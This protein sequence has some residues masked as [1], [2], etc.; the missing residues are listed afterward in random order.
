[1]LCKLKSKQRINELLLVFTALAIAF[2]QQTAVAQNNFSRS[3]NVELGNYWNPDGVIYG[4]LGGFSEFQQS[5]LATVSYHES[6]LG[7]NVSIVHRFSGA[8]R[9][10]FNGTFKN[11]LN[12][13]KQTADGNTRPMYSTGNPDR[14]HID[15][16]L[17]DD[18]EEIAKVRQWANDYSASGIG[19]M[20]I[21][22]A[23]EADVPDRPWF[24]DPQL[25]IDWWRKFVEVV[26]TDA[27]GYNAPTDL[28]WL[29]SPT[30]YR[31]NRDNS[32]SNGKIV[33]VLQSHAAK[34]YP[35]A[36]YVDWIGSS[37][38]DSPCEYTGRPL[39]RWDHEG[40]L[41]HA[42]LWA[43]IIAPDKPYMLAEWGSELAESGNGGTRV[44]FFDTTREMLS[45]SKPGFNQIG[46]IVYFDRDHD[47]GEGDCNW[48]FHNQVSFP[49]PELRFD[50]G[51]NAQV[52]VGNDP[53]FWAYRRLINTPGLI[54]PLGDFKAPVAKAPVGTPSEPF[55]GVCSIKQVG[56][57]VEVNWQNV[58][59]RNVNLQ[60]DGSW[61]KTIEP[62][63]GKFLDTDV[64]LN[65]THFYTARVRIGSPAVVHD[66]DCGTI[67]YKRTV[68][69]KPNVAHACN[70]KPATH[71]GTEGDDVIV[72]T[73][74]N[75]V[76][77]GLG[78]NDRIDAL[79]GDDVICA[80]DGNDLVEGRDGNDIIF[81]GRGNDELRGRGGA[82]RINGGAGNDVIT[83]NASN[84]ILNG[85]TGHDRVV[86]GSG[87]EDQCYNSE[88]Y[89][90]C[91]TVNSRSP[92]CLA[93]A[94]NNGTVTLS[95]DPVPNVDQYH[96]R[97]LNGAFVTTVNDAAFWFGGSSNRRYEVRYRVNGK[98]VDI[99]CEN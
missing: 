19:P 85:E 82:D 88:T 58:G 23:H 44:K 10:N 69:D 68:T 80:G 62:P 25:F 78:G 83:G 60:R 48:S 46:A 31:F 74:G 7:H 76:I 18:P 97:V 98:V 56:N 24:K 35:G 9:N 43:S 3:S 39:H 1:M 93:L 20:F 94:N 41:E 65:A 34:L 16:L 55:N 81:G 87:A 54:V 84:D 99:E 29:W 79:G 71:V 17:A 45:S 92:K 73:S 47:H 53:D 90:T 66:L 64:E 33:P 40:L 14:A 86:G 13:L 32:Q 91:E 4:Y 5:S 28:I 52:K 2:T 95:W 6:T 11:R 72:G 50:Q 30:R 15:A 51:A 21:R 67:T 57:G 42:T 70:G 38:Y 63:V 37:G 12:L 89:G 49:R 59:N 26:E 75:D 22:L 27:P 61:L 96:V 77:V 8:W 36:E